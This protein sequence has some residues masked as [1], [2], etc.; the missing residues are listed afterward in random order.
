[1]RLEAVCYVNALMQRHEGSDMISINELEMKLI[2]PYAA[3]LSDYFMITV[4]KDNNSEQRHP[5]AHG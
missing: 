5:I 3:N 1:M 4:L 2:Q